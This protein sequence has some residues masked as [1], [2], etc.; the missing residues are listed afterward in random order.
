MVLNVAANKKLA[1][2]DVKTAFL[3]GFIEE[4]MSHSKGYEDGTIRVCKL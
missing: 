2:F 3:N 1:Q 4:D